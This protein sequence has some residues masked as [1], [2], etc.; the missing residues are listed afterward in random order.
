MEIEQIVVQF[1]LYFYERKSGAGTSGEGQEK[2]A[3][4]PALWFSTPN[5]YPFVLFLGLITSRYSGKKPVLLP[6]RDVDQTRVSGGNQAYA[7]PRHATYFFFLYLRL[8]ETTIRRERLI[9]QSILQLLRNACA[10]DMDRVLN[11]KCTRSFPL[12]VSTFTFIGWHIRV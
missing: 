7:F 4:F 1:N 12:T 9:V 3:S 5:R 2:N 6:R 11:E 8:M 10:R